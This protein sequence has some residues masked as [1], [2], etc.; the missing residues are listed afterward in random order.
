MLAKQQYK[1]ASISSVYFGGNQLKP[2]TVFRTANLDDLPGIVDLHMTT[3]TLPP[4]LQQ[5]ITEGR[6][7]TMVQS[8]PSDRFV[9]IAETGSPPII[10]GTVVVEKTNNK[11]TKAE[12]DDVLI[13]PSYRGQG[14]GSQMVTQALSTAKQLDVRKVKLLPE[15]TAVSFYKSLG[16]SFDKKNGFM[17][18]KL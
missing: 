7:G 16:F 8:L 5:Q 18:K 13:H 12:L 3:L 6:W 15:P 11:G 2:T 14:L 4:A 1:F 9:T 10:V 17:V